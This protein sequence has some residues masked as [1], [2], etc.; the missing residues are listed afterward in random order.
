MAT[1]YEV[2]DLAGVSLATVSRVMNKNTR[3]SEKT[4]KKV[5]DAMA[6]LG[7]KPNSIAQSLA[8]NRTNSVGILVSEL[9]GPFFAQMMAG[10][11]SE[12]RAA[13]KHVI[14]TTGHSEDDKEK[15]GIEFLISRKCDALILHVEAVSDEYLIELSQGKTPVYLINR[16]VKPLKDN[17]ISLDNELGGYLASKSILEQGHKKIAYIAGPQFKADAR[18]R[19]KG[20]KKALTEHNIEFNN[21]LFYEGDFN[22][23]GGTQ[24]LKQLINKNIPFTALV[25]ANDEMASGAMKYAREHGYNLP[26]DLSVIGFDNVI[27]ANYLYPTLTTIDN[28]VENM[29]QM[30]AKMVLK[31]IYQYK[32][33]EINRVFEPTL[34]NRDSTQALLK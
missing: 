23:V 10:I 7:Y 31:D 4:T 11:E 18:N 17:C 9:H 19:L 2:S 25:C 21:E 1:I 30:A 16:Y 3:V 5:L 22:E 13:G 8:S 15:D 6:Q 33:L 29:G 20:H 32:N 28:P 27:F 24:A 34:I 14:I 12:L 26:N